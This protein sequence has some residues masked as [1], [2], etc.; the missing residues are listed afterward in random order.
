M[1]SNDFSAASAAEL[2]AALRA[3]SAASF[4]SALAE[5]YSITLSADILLSADLPGIHLAHDDTLRIVGNAHTLDGG[6]VARGFLAYAGGIEISDLR[7]ARTR[8]AGGAGGDGGAQSAAW[9]RSGAGGGGAGLGGGLLVAASASVVLRDVS[10]Q[11]STAQ[12]GSGGRSTGGWGGGGGGLGAPGHT[13]WL[14]E[15]EMYGPWF[16]L[17]GGGG[18]VSG[19]ALPPI[20]NAAP[21]GM[22]LPAAP[23]GQGG[24]D[25]GDGGT[26]RVEPDA[27]NY[28]YDYFHTEGGAGGGGV[29]G[30]AGTWAP[31]DGGAGGFGGGG[32][33]GATGSGGAGG[34]GGGGGGG[35]HLGG[36]GGFGGGGG[37]GGDFNE[38]MA[39]AGGFGAGAGAGTGYGGGGGLGAGGAIFV[40]QGGRL[41]IGA[42]ALSGGSVAGGAGV[43]GGGN[44]QA[45]GAGVFV[46]G[47]G[48]IRLAP[49]AGEV[50]TIADG[51]ADVAGS[52]GAA[53][54]RVGLLA[55]GAGTVVLSGANSLSGGIALAAGTLRLGMP[56]AAGAGGIAFAGPATLRI[57][58][59]AMPA[60]TIDFGGRAAPMLHLAG[61]PFSADSKASLAAG[62][63]TV[64]GGGA[65]R[66]LAVAGVPAGTWLISAAPGGG[67]ALTLAG[68]GSGSQVVAE[69]PFYRALAPRQDAA[70]GGAIGGAPGF[71]LQRLG[72]AGAAG[73]VT[74]FVRGVGAR[75]AGA[76]DF[77]GGVFPGGVVS[78]AAGET[79][80]P[81]GIQFAGDL[82]LEPDEDFEI[83]LGA[84]A[85]SALLD[86]PVR[87]RIMG[88]D[89]LVSVLPLSARKL[90]G[91]GGTTAFT[92]LAT[93]AGGG[94]AALEVGWQ[95]TGRT[96]AGAH[97]A[98]A[99]DFA[100]GVLPQGVVSFAAGQASRVITVSV[101]ADDRSEANETFALGLV[102]LP[103]G[104]G[105]AQGS[106]LGII[107]G[108]DTSFSIGALGGPRLEGSGTGTTDV[109]FAI[110]RQGPAGVAQTID[111]AVA[112]AAGGGALAA[113]A[114]DFAGGIL[115]SGTVS[116]APQDSVKLITVQ[117]RPDSAIELNERF[118]VT[119]SNP[120]GGARIGRAGA[121]GIILNDDGARYSIGAAD[122][123]RWE[124]HGG[125]TAFTF[126]V[127]RNGTPSGTDTVDWAVTPGGFGGTLAARAADF[128]GGAMPS[129]SVSFAP[130]EHRKTISIAV[131][132]NTA[133]E[134]HRSFTVTLANPSAGGAI[135]RAAAVGAILD[136]D[137]IRVGGGGAVTGTSGPD[138]FEIGAGGG[139]VTGLGG[140]DRF[141]F[142]GPAA[143]GGGETLILGFAPLPGGV[144]DLSAID[145]IAGTV[146]NDAFSF[147]G[148][149][150]FGGTPGQLRWEHFGAEEIPEYPDNPVPEGWLVQGDVDGD[151]T[152][153]L[154]IRLRLTANPELHQMPAQAEWFAL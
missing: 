35:L 56:A 75:A 44:G 145:A 38:S 2:D 123:I 50:L 49:G 135:G 89:T 103:A 148:D 112:G 25:G 109:T 72:P 61:L 81:L 105:A 18:G 88:D 21:G 96:A 100:G 3:V 67:T 20:P 127:S 121:T 153:D 110:Y 126:H 14:G 85:P 42:G 131:A 16:P 51:I 12:G 70:E 5:A 91:T 95:V 92:F 87:G 52:G 15:F 79:H 137:P 90:E 47:T 99:A 62:L 139:V 117:V 1:S 78:F 13:G 27:D 128:A 28:G 73:E 141:A 76:E 6:N 55:E 98:D 151:G 104:V 115:P 143:G 68:A 10:F 80:K 101:A 124:G 118:A 17:P 32:G 29:G 147:I 107:R 45:F 46:E 140:A 154:S 36:A 11:S 150:S 69:T 129:G 84:A 31:G 114:G 132:G 138:M 19:S 23:G 83:V 65:S 53:D 133:R 7:I 82:T 71:A 130:G 60:A 57:D 30:R 125:A 122:S 39:A 97:A 152:A 142:L 37:G 144:V 106:A 116:F 40:Q 136:D 86:A 113:G 4:G 33:G 111:W 8:A 74:W 102:G 9:G 54:Q 43:S 149:A 77:A 34:Y 58:G 146:A 41:S 26:Y 66:G 120:T 119:L 93:R 94:L 22:G 108:D 64:A 63:L 59:D 134:F 48:L 24:G